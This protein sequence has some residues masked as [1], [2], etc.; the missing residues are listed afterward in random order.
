MAKAHIEWFDAGDMTLEEYED[1][2]RGTGVWP[3]E[4]TEAGGKVITLPSGCYFIPQQYT[5]KDDN[6][7]VI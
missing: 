3:V 1:F 4:N 6:G 2:L 7:A 5:R